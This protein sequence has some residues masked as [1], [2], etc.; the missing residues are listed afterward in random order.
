[1]LFSKNILSAASLGMFLPVYGAVVHEKRGFWPDPYSLR[2]FSP[3]HFARQNNLSDL[4]WSSERSLL[5]DTGDEPTRTRML[6]KDWSDSTLDERQDPTPP[7]DIR[8]TPAPTGD[9]SPSTT[10]HIE[11]ENDF[12]LIMPGN[13]GELVSDAE[14]DGISFCTPG[15]ADPGCTNRLPDG[16]ITA[17][18]IAKADDGSWIQVTGCLDTSK[19]HLDPSDTGGQFDVRYPQGAQ[20]TFGGY[21]ASFIELVE[22]AKNRFCIRCCAS[23]N[24]QENCNS[25]RDRQGCENAVPGTYDF[26]DQGVSCSA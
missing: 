14:A 24:D 25:H 9:P 17:A 8:P 13:P 26:P 4:P 11:N 16:F 22:P 6:A 23:E 1:M 2:P 18:A 10:V 3:F 7:E 21:G 15:T 12:A 19:F 20:C 5:S